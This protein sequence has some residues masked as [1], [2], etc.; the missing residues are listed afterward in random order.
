MAKTGLVKCD[1]G[2]KTVVCQDCQHVILDAVNPKQGACLCGLIEKY[3]KKLI[4]EGK[5]NVNA[6]VELALIKVGR[7]RSSGVQP[8][9]YPNVPRLCARFAAI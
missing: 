9:D 2:Y 6:L 5:A 4:A 8:F 3:R 7:R 1:Q